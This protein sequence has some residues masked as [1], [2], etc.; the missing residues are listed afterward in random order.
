LKSRALPG[1]LRFREFLYFD[2]VVCRF[3]PLI[4]AAG[5]FFCLETKEAKIQVKP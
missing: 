4:A 2:F 1:F 5:Y 3:V